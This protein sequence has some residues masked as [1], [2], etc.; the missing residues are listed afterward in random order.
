MKINIEINNPA[1][2]KIDE[3]SVKK[4]AVAVIENEARRF[5]GIGKMEVSLAFVKPEK[6]RALNK[7]F[8]GR[9]CVTDIL[10]FT[11]DGLTDNGGWSLGELIICAKQ[12]KDDAKELKTS[13]ESELV[14]VIIHGILHLFGYDHEKSEIEAETMRGKEEFY[15]GSVKLKA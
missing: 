2:A 1:G 7:K 11:G 14:W 12:V 10:S 8:R 13:F 9:D 4:T 6:I 5:G 15:L 3:K